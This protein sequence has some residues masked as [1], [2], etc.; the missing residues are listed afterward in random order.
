M[1]AEKERD[2]GMAEKT[3]YDLSRPGRT[4]VSLP[5][6]DV[7]GKPVDQLLPGWALRPRQPELPELAEIDVIRHMKM[8]TVGRVDPGRIYDDVI[9]YVEMESS[10]IG[11]YEID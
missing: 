3:I 10:T 9:D 6:C 2:K 5:A 8:K 1:R 4:G 7:P 11:H